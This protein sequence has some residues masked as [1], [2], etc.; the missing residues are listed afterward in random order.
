MIKFQTRINITEEAGY[1]RG[2]SKFSNFRFF[3]FVARNYS[4]LS[5]FDGFA[6]IFYAM[7]RSSLELKGGQFILKLLIV[8]QPNDHFQLQIQ[9]PLFFVKIHRRAIGRARVVLFIARLVGDS[10]STIIIR[11]FRLDSSAQKFGM[12][13]QIIPRVN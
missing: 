10:A 5:S 12:E 11:Y 7:I 13:L 3:L 2:T 8:V 1:V 4:G 6:V 9:Q